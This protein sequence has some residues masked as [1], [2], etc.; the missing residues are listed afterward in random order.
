VIHVSFDR[1]ICAGCPVRAQ[2]TKSKTTG[3]ELSFR[4]REYH[5]ALQ[6]A[7]HRQTTAEFKA[8][9]AARSG[10]EGTLSQSIRVGDVRHARYRGLGKT[11]LQNALTATAVNLLR[12]IAWLL[13]VPRAPTRQT[14]FARLA[15][16]PV[17]AP[18]PGWG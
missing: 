14:A 8:A 16:G 3:R 11:R 1:Q 9:Y 15:P 4:S 10:I 13:E 17:A 6:T 18:L 12:V 7:R 2:C 5:I